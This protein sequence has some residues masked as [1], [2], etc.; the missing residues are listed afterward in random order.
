MRI[1]EK[2]RP[3]PGEW[4]LAAATHLFERGGFGPTP[5]EAEAAL[6]GSFEAA[7]ERLFAPAGHHPA[8]LAG[9]HSLVDAGETNAL[10]AWWIELMRHGG[11]PL[12]ER[13]A[14]MWHDHFATSDAKVKDTR[15]MYGQNRLFRELGAGDFRELFFAVSKEPCMLKWLDGDMNRAGHPNENFAREVMELF[16]LGIGNYTEAD[17]Q[18]LARAL[19]GWGT[20]GA[21]KRAFRFRERYHDKGE[22]VIFGQHGNFTPDEAIEL[23][24]AQPA[25]K[26]HVA[27]RLLAEFITTAP[28]EDL[29]DGVAERLAVHDWHI[30]KVVRELLS[31]RLFFTPA[32]RRSRIAGPVELAVRA[33]RRLNSKVP[34]KDIAFATADMG[35]RL[36][37]PPSVKGWDG[38]RVWINAG[39]WTARH[40]ALVRLVEREDDLDDVLGRPRTKTEAAGLALAGLLPA[41]EDRGFTYGLEREVAE[42]ASPAEALRLA[43]ALVLTSPEYQLI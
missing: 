21:Q 31:S 33:V 2:W 3:G 27:R 26:R 15:L 9:A 28:D 41:L 42:A 11:D 5:G 24:L 12:G 10:A 22:K 25:A 23:V 34:S 37:F 14:L 17:I 32:T 13:L 40:N 36:F 8:L 43:T 19:S 1:L 7:I 29:V 20:G 30:G 4:N 38:G 6:E 16:G 35:Q 39:T 18:E